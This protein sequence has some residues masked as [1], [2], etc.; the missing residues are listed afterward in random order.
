MIG[1]TIFHYNITGKIAQGGTGGVF[2]APEWS[3]SGSA[4]IGE[5]A[6]FIRRSVRQLTWLWKY[7]GRS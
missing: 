4:Q 6:T 2:L 1:E 7:A 5:S 3:R